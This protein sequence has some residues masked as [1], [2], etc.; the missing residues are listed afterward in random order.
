MKRK[1]TECKKILSNHISSKAIISKTHKEFIQLN[2]K[3]VKQK[4]K[5]LKI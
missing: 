1:P 5:Y 3:K 2:S 4:Q